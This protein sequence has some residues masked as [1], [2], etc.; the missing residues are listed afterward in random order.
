MKASKI[1]LILFS[2][3]VIINGQS[4]GSWKVYSDLKEVR[5][6]VVSGNDIW[7][8]TSGG[9]FRTGI[10]DTSINS[11]S[12]ADGFASQSYFSIINDAEGKIWFGAK[13][14]FINILDLKSGKIDLIVDFYNT[15]KSKK[16]VNDLSISGD[17]ILASLDFGLSLLSASKKTLMDS[18]LKFGNLSSESRVLSALKY[19]L[20]FVCTEFGIA[21]QKQ[22]ATNLAAPESW[23]SY[24]YD[25]QLPFNSASKLGVYNSNVVLGTTTGIFKYQNNSWSLLALKDSSIIDLH[26][27]AS[28]LYIITKSRLYSFSNNQITK[29][30]ENSNCIFS[31]V[32]STAQAVYVSSNK[33]IIE[34]KNGKARIIAPNSPDGNSFVNMSV[35]PSGTLW[36]ATG[37]DLNGKGFFEFD[38]NNWK[39][40]NKT[41][42]KSILSNAFYSVFAGSD[43]SVYLGNWGLGAAIYKNGKIDTITINNTQMVG[44]PNDVKFLVISDIKTDSKGN[45]WFLNY[46]SKNA[47]PLNVFTKDKKWYYY[48]LTNPLVSSNEFFDKMI[49][50]QN[51]T[52]WFVAKEGNRGVYYFNENGTYSTLTDDSQ[53]MISTSDGLLS[54]LINCL[55]LDKRGQIWIG[56]NIGITLIADPTKPRSMMSSTSTSPFGRAIRNQNI[57]CIAVDP[58]DQKWLGTSNG[59]FVLS[60]DGYQLVNQYNVKNSPLPDNNILSIAID[61][62]SGKVYFGTDYGL[63]ELKTEFVQPNESFNTIFTY[64]NPFIVGNS[65]TPFVTIDGLVRNSNIKIMNI[66]G[67]LVCEIKSAGGRVASW[68]GKDMNGNFVS[69]GI[70]ILVASDPEANNVATAK[71]AVIRK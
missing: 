18:F 9:I 28:N 11:Y 12:K 24:T 16:T 66:S 38:G 25:A 45:A 58:I 33:G 46:I 44:I 57:N 13:E 47:K 5:S 49:I 39:I 65:E 48:T 40:Y 52:K 1:F 55:A 41:A 63:A 20:V 71:I 34:F 43:S 23:N 54:D 10:I 15:N 21:I 22:G 7:A 3:A 27:S 19:N 68:N 17:T 53:G 51:D 14:G 64:P 70:Y 30:Y 8:A 26:S 62:K 4:I 59:V 35:S 56:T 67:D 60:S 31:S 42:S 29:L 6:V 2:F 61:P 37:K 36:T 50:D 69:S 32:Y